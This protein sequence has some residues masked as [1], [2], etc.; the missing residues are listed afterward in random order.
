MPNYRVRFTAFSSLAVRNY[1]FIHFF[2]LFIYLC[3]CFECDVKEMERIVEGLS[4]Q[5]CMDFKAPQN[6]FMLYW[7]Y[8]LRGFFVGSSLKNN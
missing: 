2:Y 5:P 6:Y 1:S 4:E 8:S 3:I 7:S